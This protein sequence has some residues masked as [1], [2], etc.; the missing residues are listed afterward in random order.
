MFYLTRE[1]CM[2]LALTFFTLESASSHDAAMVSQAIQFSVVK[3][4]YF[5]DCKS[6]EHMLKVGGAHSVKYLKDNT[7]VMCTVL[8]QE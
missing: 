8:P 7:N 5:Y 3:C 4:E 1:S 6:F 2:N